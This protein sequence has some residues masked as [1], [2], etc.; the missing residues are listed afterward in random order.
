MRV[1]VDTWGVVTAAGHL[2]ARADDLRGLAP[3]LRR[4]PGQVRDPALR[5]G[6]G[7]LSAAVADLV[8]VLALDQDALA[9]TA[10]AGAR[11]YADVEQGLA[12]ASL[13]TGR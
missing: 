2:R 3:P 4:W 8:E 11:L 5:S 1:E 6:V 12:V 10:R 7:A 9:D 13:T